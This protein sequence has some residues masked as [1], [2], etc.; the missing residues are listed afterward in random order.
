MKKLAFFTFLI[1]L[2]VAA[3]VCAQGRVEHDFDNGNPIDGFAPRSITAYT[4]TKAAIT[5]PLTATGATA[6]AKYCLSSTAAGTI[7]INGSGDTKAIAVNTDYCRTVRKGVTSLV[8]TGASSAAKT[9]T[10]ERQY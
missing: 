9:I 8:F 1:V 7:Q 5:I 4:H 3:T 2:A 10:V 6:V